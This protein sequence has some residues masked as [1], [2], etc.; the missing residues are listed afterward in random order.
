MADNA[1]IVL[2][3]FETLFQQADWARRTRALFWR[4]VGPSQKLSCDRK[5]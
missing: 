1:Q 2:N 5:L 4:G 3:A